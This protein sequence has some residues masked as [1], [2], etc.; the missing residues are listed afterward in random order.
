MKQ[1]HNNLKPV[2]FSK[3]NSKRDFYSNTV[4]P[5]KIR[6]ISSKQPSPIPK[7]TRES[8]TTKLKTRRRKEIK[9]MK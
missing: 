7:A 6:I 8:R 1:K 2:G 5:W 3:S 9:Q 4:L